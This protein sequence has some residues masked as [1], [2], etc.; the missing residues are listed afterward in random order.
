MNSMKTVAIVGRPNVGKSRLFNRLAHRRIA[1]VH[2]QPGVTRDVVS[3]D[4]PEGFTLMDTGGI[5]LEDGH[6]PKVISEAMQAQAMVAINSAD[7]ILFV[8]DGQQGLTPLDQEIAHHLHAHHPKVVMVVNKMD[9]YGDESDAYEFAQLGFG[10]PFS[11]SAEHNIGL[12]EL[13]SEMFRR[14]GPLELPEPSSASRISMALIGKPNA[15][16]SSLGNRL[17]NSERFIVSEIAGTTRDCV[18]TSIRYQD[19]SGQD[20]EFRLFDTA[21]LRPKNKVDTSVEFYS[22]VRTERCIEE[23]DIVLMLIDARDG[24]SKQDKAIAGHVIDSGKALVVVVTKWDHAVDAFRNGTIDGYENLQAFEEA[25]VKGI[26]KA[27]FYLPE[28][29]VVFTSALDGD[30]VESLFESVIHLH[31]SLDQKLST[32]KLNRCIA[33]CVEA[34]SPA[35]VSGKRFKVYYGVQIGNRPFRIKLFCNRAEKLEETY[36]RYL[37]KSFI[38][39]FDLQG[40]PFRFQLIGKEERYAN[41]EE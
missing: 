2:D 1:I 12:N 20:W 3:V 40:C 36:R 39:E 24:V 38:R 18:E 11:V 32:P 31:Q 41:Q 27:F 16:K 8:A 9:Q 35:K 4:M 33:K 10:H 34:K 17:L 23:S 19:R 28:S 13:E 14:I 15:G 22:G 7:L 21:G 26:R 37:E 5:G 6:T 30:G 25:Y 29:P